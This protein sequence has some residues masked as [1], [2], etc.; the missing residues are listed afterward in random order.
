[1]QI[2]IL[3]SFC[4]NK[5]ML[6]IIIVGSAFSVDPVVDELEKEITKFIR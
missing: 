4:I 6:K 3:L 2:L 1:M 5:D